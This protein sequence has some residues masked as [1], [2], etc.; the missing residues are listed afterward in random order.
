MILTGANGAGKTNILEAISL[1]SPGRG[2]RRAKLPALRHA[3]HLSQPWAIAAFCYGLQDEVQLGVGHDQRAE[4]E[5]RLVK[6]DGKAAKSQAE[7]AQHLAMLW[8]TPQ[9]DGLFLD[10]PG[11]RRRFLDR[12]VYA[13]DPAHL[14]RVTAYEKAMRDRNKLLEESQPDSR[15]LSTLEAQMA[16]HGLALSLARTNFVAQLQTSMLHITDAFPQA[17]MQLE[18]PSAPD[19][20]EQLRA[21]R[22]RDSRAG[23]ATLGP[24]TQ[25]WLVTHRAKA[26]PAAACSTGEQKALLLA[27]LL[28]QAITRKTIKGRAPILL[29]DEVVAHLDAHRR[30]ALSEA[31]QQLDT[32]VWLTGTDEADFSAFTSFCHAYRVDEG[33]VETS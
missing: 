29:L 23:R 2:L 3:A 15:W 17:D 4:S 25:D 28:A 26:M 8:L 13:F 20:A 27:I 21:A 18:H 10:T 30:A 32:Q 11:T 24:H 22:S 33:A 19:L 9:M 16:E 1:L 5:K 31:I 14:T 7:L 6:I 12:L